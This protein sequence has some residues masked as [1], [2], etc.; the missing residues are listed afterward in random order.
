MEYIS[1]RS[2]EENKKSPRVKGT[3]DGLGFLLF[4]NHIQFIIEIPFTF[5]A[6]MFEIDERRR[7]TIIM[8]GEGNISA[9]LSCPAKLY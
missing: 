6:D 3:K 4:L 5:C 1:K 7:P 9:N 2:T 8:Q